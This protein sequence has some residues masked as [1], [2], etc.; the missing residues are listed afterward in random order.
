MEKTLWWRKAWGHLKCWTTVLVVGRFF[1]HWRQEQQWSQPKAPLSGRRRHQIGP[2]PPIQ[3][4]I[5]AWDFWNAIAVFTRQHQSAV[6]DWW[7][8]PQNTCGSWRMY[9]FF[10]SYWEGRW[11]SQMLP[12]TSVQS[13]VLSSEIFCSCSDASRSK[14][15]IL[16]FFLK[17][18]YPLNYKQFILSVGLNLLSTKIF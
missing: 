16:F 2:A 11:G 13:I 6:M 14:Y 18:L 7:G 1:Q 15:Q 9:F 10:R 3:L 12:T 4:T 17:L 5:Y 8:W